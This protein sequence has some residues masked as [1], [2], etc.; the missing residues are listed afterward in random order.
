MKIEFI[1]SEKKWRHHFLQYKSMGKKFCIQERITPKWII[2]SGPNL[3]SIMFLQP[4]FELVQDFLT[5]LA[6]CEFDEDWIHSTEKRW[7]HH[8]PHSKN[9]N[10]QERITPYWKIR[11]GV[12]VYFTPWAIC[13][14]ISYPRPG[15]LFP[16]GASCPGQFILPPPIQRKFCC[17]MF[18]IICNTSIITCSS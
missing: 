13:P 7:R 4:K 1:V 16:Q 12:P 8:F 9:G 11:P 2:W 17:V 3:N 15:Y 14:G 18:T 6:T 5:V 10:T